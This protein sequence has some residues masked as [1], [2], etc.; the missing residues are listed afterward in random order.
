M[1]LIDGVYIVAATGVV[2]MDG[3]GMLRHHL[4]RR[5][6]AVSA[7]EG[8]RGKQK[9]WR[10]HEM[11]NSHKKENKNE[12]RN[13]GYG[14]CRRDIRN[15]IGSTGTIGDMG[16]RTPNNAKALAWVE[17]TGSNA[18]AGTFADAAK[19][20]EIL[21]NC[22]S[23]AV[24]LEALKLAGAENMHGKILVDVANPLDFSKG[25]PP[26]LTVS[27]KIHWGNRFSA[28]IGS[29][30]S[31]SSQHADLINYGQSASSCRR[32]SRS[33][34]L[35]QRFGSKKNRHCNIGFIRME[36]GAYLRFSDITNARARKSSAAVDTADGEIP[37]TDVSMESGKIK[38]M[39]K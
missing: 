35:R 18:F 23:G 32:R 26:T 33:F 21:F 8:R 4:A 24:S 31:K 34:H 14:D 6:R 1:F 3:R 27:N 17:K 11:L 29:E 19:F 22:T 25:M 38:K 28:P 37:I 15:K 7:T 39:G 13:I 5:R 36:V 12:N 2:P 9:Y 20:G 30:S 10:F 16:S